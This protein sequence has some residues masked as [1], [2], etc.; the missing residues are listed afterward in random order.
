MYTHDSSETMK[1]LVSGLYQLIPCSTQYLAVTA[2]SKPSQMYRSQS[3]LLIVEGLALHVLSVQHC[4]VNFKG[5]SA[6]T[7]A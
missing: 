5:N 3:H 1:C 7:P 4:D 2:Y 6:V